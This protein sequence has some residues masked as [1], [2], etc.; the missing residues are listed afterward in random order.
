MIE[1][2]ARMVY[3]FG[4]H[5]LYASA[6][7]LAALGLTTVIRSSSTTKYWV[8]VA[9]SLNFVLP[10]GA[11]LDKAFAPHLSAARPLSFVGS[12]GLLVAEN[13]ALIGTLWLLGALLMLTRLSLRLRAERRDLRRQSPIDRVSAAEGVPVEFAGHEAPAVY[14]V[15]H[16]RISLPAGID[17]LLTNS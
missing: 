12:F 14:G 8:W 15:L 3:Y 6:V 13:V 4:V 1:H 17:R 9:T 11:L 5:L 7:W 2:I 10:L 16:S